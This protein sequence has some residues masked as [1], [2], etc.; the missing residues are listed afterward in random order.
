V[1]HL[2]SDLHDYAKTTTAVVI[3]Q[4]HCKKLLN[5]ISREIDFLLKCAYF[6]NSFTCVETSH[7]KTGICRFES[8][9]KDESRAQSAD[10]SDAY[11]KLTAFNDNKIKLRQEAVYRRQGFLTKLSPARVVKKQTPGK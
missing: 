7:S 3:L 5:M 9:Q 10:S 2:L 1:A 8:W 11:I 4:R 6:C